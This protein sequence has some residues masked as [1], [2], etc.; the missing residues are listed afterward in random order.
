MIDCACKIQLVQASQMVTLAL[1]W[2]VLYA[3]TA[4][5]PHMAMAIA[6]HIMTRILFFATDVTPG[7]MD[8]VYAS[9]D[10]PRQFSMEAVA[11]ANG[12]GQPTMTCIGITLVV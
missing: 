1:A 2:R 11:V 8:L 6:M 9:L 12:Y 10:R 4:H 3:L 5:K 7:R